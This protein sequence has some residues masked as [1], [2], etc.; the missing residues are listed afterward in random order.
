[1][2]SLISVAIV[3]FVVLLG[4]VSRR[5]HIFDAVNIKIINNIVAKFLFPII[6]CVSLMFTTFTIN[7]LILTGIF[8]SILLF[9]FLLGFL[10]KKPFKHKYKNYIPFLLTVWEC[11]FI[12]YPLYSSLVGV[13]NFYN[14]ITIDIAG[15]LFG[16]SI[17]MAALEQTSTGRKPTAKNIILSALKSGIL[18]ATILG[19]VLSTS[20]AGKFIIE[21]PIGKTIKTISEIVSNVANLIILIVVGYNITFNKEIIKAATP[22]IFIRFIVHA[23]CCATVLLLVNRFLVVSN[24]LKLAIIIMMSCPPSLSCQAFIKSEDGAKYI[25]TTNSMYCIITLIIY[26]SLSIII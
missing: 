5:L 8:F 1:M 21:K 6:V 7:N 16:F 9:T 18:I 22:V 3:L 20:G 17:F 14:I 11:G 12:G 26:V 4:F 10:V 19:I 23:I 25:A 24:E 2:S 15:L 13:D